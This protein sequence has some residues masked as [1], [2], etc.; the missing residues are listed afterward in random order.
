MNPNQN[1]QQNTSNP[2]RSIFG[3][4]PGALF[5]NLNTN[6]AQQ[7]NN[8]NNNT[9]INMNVNRPLMFNPHSDTATPIFNANT[10]GG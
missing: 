2:P 4:T 10:G 9:N 6:A 1:Q 8:N 7:N 5:G 3:G